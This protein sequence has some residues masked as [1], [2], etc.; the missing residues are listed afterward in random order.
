[1]Q[2]GLRRPLRKGTFDTQSGRDLHV[3]NRCSKTFPEISTFK[4][5][6]DPATACS[7]T[8]ETILSLFPFQHKRK[9]YRQRAS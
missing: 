8:T 7:Q 2:D 3:D 1:M 9:I 6:L 5:D 4:T